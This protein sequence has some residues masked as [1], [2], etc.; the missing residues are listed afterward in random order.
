M[1]RQERG[2]W[3][4]ASRMGVASACGESW[5][6]VTP[7]G[8]DR[9]TS[10]PRTLRTPAPPPR[11]PTT[12]PDTSCSRLRHAHG[13]SASPHRPHAAAPTSAIA[14]L[15]DRTDQMHE[16]RAGPLTGP[17]LVGRF[18]AL[19]V[20]IRMTNTGSTNTNTT[21]RYARCVP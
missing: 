9:P 6:L 5:V 16:G 13:Q 3:A 2:R 4:S 20:Y 15:H 11:L 10:C 1:P 7:K 14:S 12:Q 18:R 19:G 17:K 21:G 8:R